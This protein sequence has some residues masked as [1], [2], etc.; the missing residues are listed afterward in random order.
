MMLPH[1]A[2][3]AT[4]MRRAATSY[5]LTTCHSAS[6]HYAD[7]ADVI[8]TYAMPAVRHIRCREFHYGHY[9]A[10]TLWLLFNDIILDAAIHGELRP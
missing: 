1:A 10:T 3:A 8:S 9:A 6:F 2:S 7:A 5:A 4:Y